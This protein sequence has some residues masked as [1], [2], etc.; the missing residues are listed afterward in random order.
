MTNPMGTKKP[1][2]PG[3]IPFAIGVGLLVLG[4]LLAIANVAT[5][6]TPSGVAWVLLVVGALLASLGYLKRR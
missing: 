4:A 3:D 5:Q 2:K 1:S 6:G